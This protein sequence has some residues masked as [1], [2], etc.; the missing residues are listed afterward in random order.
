[1]GKRSRVAKPEPVTE[2]IEEFLYC[3]VYGQPYQCI[4]ALCNMASRRRMRVEGLVRNKLIRVE[5]TDQPFT[6]FQQH[7]TCLA[8]SKCMKEECI[9]PKCGYYPLVDDAT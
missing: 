1:M 7:F 8:Y 5:P 6:L 4:N 3:T 2:P 9:S